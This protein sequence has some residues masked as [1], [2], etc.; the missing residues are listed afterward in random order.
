MRGVR[1]SEASG[2]GVALEKHTIG[3]EMPAWQ[4]LIGA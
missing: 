2:M 1:L 4:V 3:L